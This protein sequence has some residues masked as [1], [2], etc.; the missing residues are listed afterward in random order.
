VA[1]G[2]VLSFDFH[3]ETGDRTDS[4]LRTSNFKVA[5]GGFGVTYT[6][7]QSLNFKLSTNSN[8]IRSNAP[9]AVGAL[10]DF[11]V[12][13]LSNV[14][15]ASYTPNPVWTFSAQFDTQGVRDSR[16]SVGGMKF[17]KMTASAIARP[18]GSFK[19][20]SLDFNRQNV[21]NPYYGNSLTDAS[22][23]R[24][25]YAV[26][27]DWLL[28]PGFSYSKSLVVD[29][30]RNLSR[31]TGLRAQYR[32]GA[33]KGWNVSVQLNHNQRVSAQPDAAN[34]WTS[35]N[36]DQDRFAVDTTYIPSGRINWKN[37]FTSTKEL[38]S[39]S[40]ARRNSITSAVSY[41][42]SPSTTLE[43]TFNNETAPDGSPGRT[44]FQLNSSTKLD[45]HFSL[46]ASL[47]KE[48]QKGANQA[49]DGTLFN[50]TLNAE[51]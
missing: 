19:L 38:V 43:F 9:A 18:K 46:G 1:G 31:N 29:R 36:N 26:S 6:P 40:P 44:M 17:D 24:A 32:P 21:P 30:S 22:T 35:S 16:E 33:L 41:L 4:T 49:Y 20:F 13:T 7:L 50:M 11:S 48:K 37:S 10:G 42:Y 25:D 2:K 28:T 8:K 3:G 15:D 51:F 14:L 23:L 47:K 45:R 27:R 34:A 39:S 5:K 12:K